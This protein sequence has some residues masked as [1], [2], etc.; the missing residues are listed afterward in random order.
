MA[1]IKC[2]ECGHQVSDKAPVCPNCGV[3]IA[4]KV[5]KCPDCG[6]VYF[7]ADAMCPH[8][9]R[10]TTKKTESA[11]VV[12]QTPPSSPIPPQPK[13]KPKFSSDPIQVP[14]KK[15]NNWVAYLVSFVIALLIC[16]V[17]FYMYKNAQDNKEMQEYEFAMK[18]KD[19]LV[20]QSYLDTYKDAPA[21]HRD[22]I[23]AHLEQIIQIDKDWTNAVVSNS[24]SILQD[25]MRKYPNSPHRAEAA[26]KIDS[27][28]WAQ[29][30]SLNTIEAYKAYMTEHENGDHY[31]EAESSMKALKVKEITP[32]ER[33]QIA[34]VF[35]RFFIS[36]NERD[37]ASLVSTV[38]EE[39][40]LLDKQQA[41]HSD[42]IEMMNKMYEK[43][44]LTNLIWRLNKDYSISKREIGND[45]YEF[46]VSF[47][48]NKEEQYADP[49]HNK[50][51]QY[52]MKA[53]VAPDGRISE[54]KMNKIIE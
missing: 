46:S 8:C 21:E 19:V 30:S 18:S 27:L 16:G 26:R 31:D 41:T 22:S 45:Q 34:Q 40:T 2:P 49:E 54:L 37:Q 25:Y 38:T 17:C 3:E 12:E 5:T 52:R 20:L 53:K 50:N 1:I 33:A 7:S 35:R 39:L 15:K 11:P 6:E 42:V 48:G 43:E 24:K 14:K 51:S 29:A 9:Y 4:D 36:I 44:G 13:E 10:P 23:S 28:D 47:T 32:E